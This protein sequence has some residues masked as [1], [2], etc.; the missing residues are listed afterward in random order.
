MGT[1]STTIYGVA[2]NLAGNAFVTDTA[3]ISSF[4]TT[5]NAYQTSTTGP[6]GFVT[7]FNA[8]GDTLLFSTSLGVTG[9]IGHAIAIDTS[10]EAKG[11][12]P[13]FLTA[14]IPDGGTP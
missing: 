14:P 7:Q 11:R 9:T 12:W 6:T 1:G 4:S 5:P 3:T 13:R 2:L 8:I 10:G